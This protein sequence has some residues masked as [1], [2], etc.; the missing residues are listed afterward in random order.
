MFGVWQPEC[1]TIVGT[2]ANKSCGPGPPAPPSWRCFSHLALDSSHRWS[3]NAPFPVCGCTIGDPL[4]DVYDECM[5]IP[6]PPPPPPPPPA[7]LQLANVLG[8]G[9]VLQRAPARAR[10]WGLAAPG[11]AVT[12]R[13]TGHTAANATAAADTA[14]RWAVFLPPLPA[15]VSGVEPYRIAVSSGRGLP[16]APV[17]LD[18]VL[19]GE[20]HVCSG[21]SNMAS[22]LIPPL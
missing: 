12:V 22:A 8:S 17:V 18:D 4:R 13:V 5:G 6:P 14:G 19:V 10:I 21:Q 1:G 20:V 11:D 16:P 2:A 3:R 15:T 7:A 9:M